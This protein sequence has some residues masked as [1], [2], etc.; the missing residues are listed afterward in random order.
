MVRRAQ[1]STSHVYMHVDIY[2]YLN[3]YKNVSSTCSSAQASSSGAEKKVSGFHSRSSLFF[4]FS[5]SV[6]L[7]LT[8]CMSEVSYLSINKD[9]CLHNTTVWLSGV[10]CFAIVIKGCLC[11]SFLPS[12]FL[13]FLKESSFSLGFLFRPSTVE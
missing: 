1:P 8:S 9:M 6:S 2:V 13:F 3:I 11:L 5:P 4:L 12:S 10:N 7:S